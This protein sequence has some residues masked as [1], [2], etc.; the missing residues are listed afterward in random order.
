M[1]LQLNGLH[2]DPESEALL[3]KFARTI[4][5]ANERLSRL[6]RRKDLGR[7]CVTITKSFPAIEGGQSRIRKIQNI[8]VTRD[9]PPRFADLPS[10]NGSVSRNGA[11]SMLPNDT[12]RRRY[13]KL[14]DI[15]G[16]RTVADPTCMLNLGHL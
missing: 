7:V 13:R 14:P 2:D 9:S 8:Y 11:H 4:S 15:R 12:I 16:A 3:K 5:A 10:G 1:I 6:S